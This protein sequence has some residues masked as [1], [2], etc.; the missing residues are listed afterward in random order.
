M[1]GQKRHEWAQAYKNL[2][3]TNW[4]KVLWSDESKFEVYGSRR[5]VFVRRS[6]GERLSD[7]CIVPTNKHGGGSMMRAL[8]FR[9]NNDVVLN[10]PKSHDY[11]LQSECIISDAN[12]AQARQHQDLFYSSNPDPLHVFVEIVLT[13]MR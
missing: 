4:K 1:S 11:D 3:I 10:F 8:T 2:T 13:V 6:A 9:T 7:K 5:R 12:A